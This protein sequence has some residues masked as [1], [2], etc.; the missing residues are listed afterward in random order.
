M[1]LRISL[2]FT[3]RSTKICTPV[4]G[5]LYEPGTEIFIQNQVQSNF[6]IP[7]KLAHEAIIQ[8][9]LPRQFFTPNEFDAY[10]SLIKSTST[11]KYTLT[12]ITTPLV[13]VIWPQPVTKYTSTPI[14]TPDGG[15]KAW[16]TNLGDNSLGL[17]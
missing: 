4:R 6:A 1:G 13:G 16:R 3:G 2:G 8:N 17:A 12:P 5:V 11:T 9:T 15:G 7:E 10:L 14:F